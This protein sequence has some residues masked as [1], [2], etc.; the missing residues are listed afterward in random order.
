MKIENVNN[1]SRSSYSPSAV[2]SCCETRL[3]DHKIQSRDVHEKLSSQPITFKPFSALALGGSHIAACY[4]LLKRTRESVRPE[5]TGRL[6][7][8]GRRTAR[9]LELVSKEISKKRTKHVTIDFT[10]TTDVQL[11]RWARWESASRAKVHP[12]SFLNQR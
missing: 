7:F 5:K 4:E 1:P 8:K 12:R 2:L 6:C 9:N 3:S 10:P 11:I